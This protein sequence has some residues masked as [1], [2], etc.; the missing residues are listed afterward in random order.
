MLVTGLVFSY[1]NGIIH[2]YYMVA[3]APGIAALV[4]IGAMALW[5]ERLGAGGR[6]TAAA[7]VAG[8]AALAYVLLDRTPDWLPWLRWVVVVAGAAAAGLV[9]AA[10]WLGSRPGRAARGW[11][12]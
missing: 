1:M 12:W 5:Q 3:L 7:A 10:P 2:P 8:S 11:P 6:I 4:G 9:L